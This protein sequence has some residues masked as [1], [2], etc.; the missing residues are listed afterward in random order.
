MKDRKEVLALLIANYPE[1]P[2][3]FFT[4]DNQ[5]FTDEQLCTAHASSLTDKTYEW[6][7]KDVVI[8]DV[9]QQPILPIVKQDKP[10][11]PAD[12]QAEKD[13]KEAE[14]EAKKLLAPRY[15]ELFAKHAAPQYDLAKIQ[16]LIKAEELRLAEV[17]K[18]TASEE[19][20][21]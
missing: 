21:A 12:Q 16:E 2:G 6:V 11:L 19:N 8:D 3:Y 5:A 13:A 1:T 15:F 14:K 20:P 10:S 4:S 18:Q 17:A 9:K 7:D